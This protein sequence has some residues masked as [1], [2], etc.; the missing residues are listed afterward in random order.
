[1]CLNS[2]NLDVGLHPTG[3]QALGL[4]ICETEEESRVVK[5]IHSLIDGGYYM[6]KGVLEWHPN[7]WYREGRKWQLSSLPGARGGYQL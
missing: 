6:P 4:P 2:L 7:M 1:M 5:E 3:P